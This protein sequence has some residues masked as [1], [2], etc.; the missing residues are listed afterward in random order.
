M[1]DDRR[2][3]DESNGRS[4]DIPRGRESTG[5]LGVALSGGG[6]RALA[7]LGVLEV[8]AEL[9][10][11]V[12]L[13]AGTSMG[14]ILAG[15]YAAGVPLPRLLQFADQAHFLDVAAP[16]RHWLGLFGQRKLADYLSD[17]LG[18][19]DIR[20]EDLSIACA[21]V[22]ADLHTGGL[23][24][25]DSGPLLPALLATAAFPIVFAPVKYD[26]RWL[27]DG[28]VLNNL[29]VD[30]VR[31]MGADKVLAVSVPPSLSASLSLEDDSAGGSGRRILPLLGNPGFDWRMP[32]LIGE[33]A[34]TIAIQVITE[35]R[36][37]LCPP[38]LLLEVTV[39]DQG[40]FIITDNVAVI[41]AGRRSARERSDDLRNLVSG[42]LPAP[43]RGRLRGRMRRL[44][45]AW[46]ELR[47][48]PS[49]LHPRQVSSAQRLQ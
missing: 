24:I 27:V 39:P 18:S 20:F 3:A 9:G 8:L 2:A 36:L 7:H 23:V 41:E 44:R 17:L 33:V 14:G 11:R 49:H 37:E 46:S 22:T 43:W 4:R 26:G 21:V 13:I 31:D 42:P 6:L 38:D 1:R 35:R 10:A 40:A 15:L 45:R 5:R 34:Y 28:G 32:F 47:S 30:V 48:Q 16:D 19:E 25:L 12:D 29:P